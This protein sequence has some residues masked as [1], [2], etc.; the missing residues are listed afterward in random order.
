MLSRRTVLGIDPGLNKTGWGVISIE[1][2]NLKY[3]AHGVVRPDSKKDLASRLNT[4]YSEVSE[5]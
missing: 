5:V 1:G 3:I 2:N 4:I